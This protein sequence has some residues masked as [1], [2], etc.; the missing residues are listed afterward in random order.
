MRSATGLNDDQR[1]AIFKILSA[2]DY[3]LV[4]G[5]PGTGKT[6][7]IVHAVKALLTR[8]ASILLTSYTNSAVDNILLKLKLQGVDFVRL[9]RENAIHPDLKGHM[10]DGLDV[11]T[12]QDLE[13]RMSAVRVVAVTCLGVTHP[14]LTDRKFDVCIVD[15]AGQITLPVCLGPLR[16]A[17]KFVLVGD[18]YQLPPL[19]RN[20][21]ARERGLTMS[22]FRRLSEA[23]PQAIAA[24]QCQYRMSA[25][26][27][28]LCN[29]L[30][31]GDRLRCGSTEVA[32]GRLE[33]PKHTALCAPSWLQ[34]VIDAA[35]SVV[36]VN[37]DMLNAQEERCQGT[38]HN[39][40]EASIV[41]MVVT[42]LLHLGV[43]LKDIGVISPYNFQVQ[44]IRRLLVSSGLTALEVHTIDRFQ[45]RD[46]E[47][48]L[49]SFV[50]SSLQGRSSST[51]LAD[52][53][54][55]N[56]A[57]TRAKK[58]LVLIGSQKTLSSTPVLNLL[59]NKVDEIGGLINIPQD[60]KFLLGGLT[61]CQT[62][63]S[64]SGFEATR[65]QVKTTG[66]SAPT[67]LMNAN[68]IS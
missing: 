15:E 19:V 41:V 26:I 4:L 16:F 56:V 62:T 44:H 14:L 43:D 29:A 8:G 57:I 24:L 48:V 32:N 17:N 47:C 13:L 51:L 40:T 28:S 5:M 50:K 30:I 61:R 60:A 49:V 1:R 68:G 18:H 38:T 33:F 7:T 53:Q 23:H 67:N 52:W 9:G 2:R 35:K 10:I 6:S 45:G 27:M 54:R 21:E 11:I 22:L 12:V 25:G 55:I 64:T 63:H 3:A 65:P 46:K 31:Y 39:M 37:T 34:Q 66:L 36:F 42:Q 20:V 58:K 59:I